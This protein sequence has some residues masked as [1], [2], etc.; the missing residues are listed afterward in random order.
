MFSF[1]RHNTE[2]AEVSFA[3]RFQRLKVGIHRQLMERLDLSQ[4]D[5][6]KPEQL[7]REIR[8]LTR[9]LTAET[10][11]LLSEPD[12]ERLVEELQ[13]EIFGL[14]PLEPLMKDPTISDILVNGPRTGITSSETACSK[15]P[16]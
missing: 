9:E 12:R 4:L 10:T 2:P 11:E 13:A 15:R 3:E 6:V 16:I 7:R 1:S 8:Q 5:V 14:G